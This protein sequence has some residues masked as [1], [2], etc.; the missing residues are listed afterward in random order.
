[1]AEAVAATAVGSIIV[2][3]LYPWFYQSPAGLNGLASSRRGLPI[4]TFRFDC[5]WDREDEEEER[6]EVDPEYEQE[7][8]ERKAQVDRAIAEEYA[9]THGG[10]QQRQHRKGFFPVQAVQALPGFNYVARGVDTARDTARAGFGGERLRSPAAVGGGGPQKASAVRGG[11]DGVAGGLPAQRR[12]RQLD[13]HEGVN[14]DELI[15]G[16]AR[17]QRPSN[18][19]ND[20]VVPLPRRRQSSAAGTPG[21]SELTQH[22]LGRFMGQAKQYARAAPMNVF[23]HRSRVN[24]V[25]EPLITVDSP[26]DG[27]MRV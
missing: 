14:L 6:D 27:P 12:R 18:N 4:T 2:S 17:R 23:H 24:A 8:A 5:G 16:R 10:R 15:G 19:L 26:G 1:M 7:R 25:S 20:V 3:C 9:R 22:G 11:D 21:E 13:Q